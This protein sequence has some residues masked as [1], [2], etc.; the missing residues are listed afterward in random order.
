M[1]KRTGMDLWIA[2]ICAAITG[3]AWIYMEEGRNRTWVMAA[4]I[5]AAL[6]FILL[7]LFEKKGREKRLLR[8]STEEPMLPAD[9]GT[10]SELALLSEEDTELMVWDMYGKVSLVIGRDMGE[11]QVDVDLSHSPYSGMVDVEHAVLNFSGGN[12]Y[13]EDLGSTNGISIRKAQDG[14]LYKI[15]ANTP[16]RVENGDVLSV[17]MNRLLIR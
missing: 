11:N 3:I 12:W 14:R 9:T 5:A 2:C 13:I 17:G 16:C 8:G 15:S 4:G 10:V 7:A 1:D 6:F